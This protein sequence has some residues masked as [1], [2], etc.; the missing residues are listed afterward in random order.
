M[1]YLVLT[2]DGVGSTLLQRA[3]TVYL[4]SSGVDYYNT[5]ELLNGLT[6][7]KNN[8][9]IKDFSLEYTQSLDQIQRLLEKNS[10][11]LVS[12][13]AD[14]HVYNRLECTHE[15]YNNFYKFCNQYFDK[16]LYCIREPYEYALSWAIRNHSSV[17]NVYTVNDRVKHHGIDKYCDIDLEYFQ[18]KLAQYQKY[19]YWVLDNFDN[20]ISVEYNN[21]NFDIDST[22]KKITNNTD[23]CISDKF[24]ISLSEYSKILYKISL[25]K[26]NLI[27]G[28]CVSKSSIKNTIELYRYQA[29]LI[30]NKKII[31]RIPIKMN[32]LQD[33]KRKIL[34]FDK[35]IDVY[36]NWASQT[37]DYSLIN[38][39]IINNRIHRERKSYDL[40][41]NSS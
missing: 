39:E 4:N 25:K 10:A 24:D 30:E 36:N 17:L 9:L 41:E 38:F 21:L 12:R 20:A 1:N 15:N 5:H 14:Y 23:F 19:Q 7:N 11:R 34:N 32:T 29:E 6:L 18:K 40:T 28:L 35:T 22:I 27:D 13:M 8:S 26:Q 2:P 33:K 37:N 3:L 31:N 16:I